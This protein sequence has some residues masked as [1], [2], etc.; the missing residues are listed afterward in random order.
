MDYMES[1]FTNWSQVENAIT[2]LAGLT[3][4]QH[5][6]PKSNATVHTAN[7]NPSSRLNAGREVRGEG[8]EPSNP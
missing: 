6:M 3:L 4:S 2:H 1:A 7:G 5:P 8:F